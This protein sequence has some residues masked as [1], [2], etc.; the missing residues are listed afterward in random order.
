VD[1]VLTLDD[2]VFWGALPMLSD[3][4]DPKVRD[5]TAQL[6]FRRLPK[7]IDIRGKLIAELKLREARGKER[8]DL[9]KRLERLIVSIESNLVKWAERNSGEQTPRILTD[10]ATRDPYKRFEESKGPL[11][12]IHI[13]LADNEIRDVATCSS[14]IAAVESFSLFRA[15]VRDDVAGK[16]VDEIVKAA[17][18]EG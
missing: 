3:A 8:A 10:R 6:L 5:C 11:N 1:R 15:Y 7:C 14:V 12:Q 4:S 9:E 16:A 18:K 17:I 2:S 13:R